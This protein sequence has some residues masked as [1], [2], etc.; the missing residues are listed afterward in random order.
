VNYLKYNLNEKIE[1]RKIGLIIKEE[2]PL[3]VAAN[4]F[5]KHLVE[6]SH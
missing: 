5:F 2:I 3:S 1:N 4:K 6:T